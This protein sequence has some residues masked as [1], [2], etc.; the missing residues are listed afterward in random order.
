MNHPGRISLLAA[1]LSLLLVACGEKP[2]TTAAAMKVNGE[3]ISTAEIEAKLQSYA[4]LPVEQ[5]QSVTDT[6]LTSYADMELLRQAALK[7]K[8]DHDAALRARLAG[9][10]RLILANAY[11]EKTMA[12]VTKPAAAEIKA[13]YD[14]HPDRFAQRKRYELRE[15][16]IL[17]S[18]ATLAEA[19][20]KATE[21]NDLGKL[22]AWLLQKK[23]SHNEQPLSITSEKVLESV[24]EKL[25]ATRGGEIIKLPGKDKMTV[26]LVSKVE[27]QPLSLAQATDMIAN[28]LY[29]ERQGAATKNMMK[30]LREKAKIEYLPPYKTPPA[31]S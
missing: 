15:M 16:V 30:T 28:Q 24:L 10:T 12:A 4:H 11:I 31:A 25:R 6:I 8:L 19:D 22:G 1:T 3:V 17:G 13:Y 20:A 2:A 9:T 18:P 27:P 26:L 29:E 21:V 5:K 14:K 7:D 23:I